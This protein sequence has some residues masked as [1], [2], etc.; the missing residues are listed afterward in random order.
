M[1]NGVQMFL[2]QKLCIFH[3]CE[4]NVFRLAIVGH[5]QY[6]LLPNTFKMQ[7]WAGEATAANGNFFVFYLQHFGFFDF[8]T[9][10]IVK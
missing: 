1:L 4:E 2:S 5:N 8:L 9:F 7:R 6:K 3:E 10:F